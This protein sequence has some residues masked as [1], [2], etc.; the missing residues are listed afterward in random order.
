[1]NATARHIALTLIACLLV[2][3]GAAAAPLTHPIEGADD[4]DLI[5]IDLGERPAQR[6][7]VQAAFTLESYRP[8]DVA[9]LAMWSSARSVTLQFFHAG[10]ETSTSP[11]TTRWPAIRSAGSGPRQRRRGPRDSP[12]H[13]ALGDRL[14]LRAARGC[15]GPHRLRAVRPPPEPAR[16]APHRRRLPDA[17]MAGVQP[18]RRRPRRQARHVVRQLE[19]SHRKA[20]QAVQNRG[21]PRHYRN[22][23]ESFLRWL[24]RRTTTSTTCPT[25]S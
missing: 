15:E 21:T 5:G 19:P 16:R 11:A 13:R 3:L 10:T 22:Y 18:P 25:A 24:S 17:D 23:E 2:V 1:M 6:P 20:A 4:D 14:L 9:R 12:S 7:T 8:G